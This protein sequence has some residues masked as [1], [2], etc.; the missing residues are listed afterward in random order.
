[1]PTILVCNVKGGSGKTTLT[2]VLACEFARHG[3]SVAVVDASSAATIARWGKARVD[4]GRG[5]PF[6]IVTTSARTDLI[7]VMDRY[8][9]LHDFVLIDCAHTPSGALVRSDLIL[10]P[11]NLS[12][13]DAEVTAKVVGRIQAQIELLECEIPIRIV[14]SRDNAAM[15]T[16]VAQRIIADIKR[17]EL[18]LLPASLVE[19][20]AYRDIFDFGQTLQELEEHKTRSLPTARENAYEVAKSVLQTVHEILQ[21]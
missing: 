16:R 8:G 20:A 10:V 9:P 7:G 1:M 5:V 4:Q 3:A 19:R 2:L 6:E 21:G 11:F 15:R 14:C 18:R 13:I 17:A 12:G